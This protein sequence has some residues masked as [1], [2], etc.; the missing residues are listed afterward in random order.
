VVVVAVFFGISVLVVGRA[1]RINPQVMMAA[2]MVSYIV[3]FIG[4]AIVMV[5]LS[6]ST[7]FSPQ[8]ARA[9][10]HR[11]RSHLVRRAGRHLDEAQGPL[12]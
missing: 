3:K 4:L 5:A 2:A 9:D 1:A 7:T 11:P 12:R 6:R 8:A 10:G